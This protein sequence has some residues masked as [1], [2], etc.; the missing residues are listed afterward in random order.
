MGRYPQMRALRNAPGLRSTIRSSGDARRWSTPRRDEAL[1]DALKRL[2]DPQDAAT[3]RDDMTGDDCGGASLCVECGERPQPAR[4]D[5]EPGTHHRCDPCAR[6][7]L[8]RRD[9]RRRLLSGPWTFAGW[10]D[11][12]PCIECGSD[13]P[14]GVLHFR[15]GKL[16]AVEDRRESI[17]RPC[18]AGTEG[19]RAIAE[20]VADTPPVLQSASL[21]RHE[22]SGPAI[23][24][25]RTPPAMRVLAFLALGLVDGM[26]DIG[27]QCGIVT[28]DSALGELMII[29]AA[30]D[31]QAI[32]V[33]GACGSWLALYASRVSV[34]RDHYRAIR[35]CVYAE[36][37]IGAARRLVRQS[38]LGGRPRS[39]ADGS[40]NP[41]TRRDA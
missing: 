5:G 16:P 35:A 12:V 8:R 37:G 20:S 11:P 18:M 28:D 19:L 36:R 38:V 24:V 13:V 4:H 10:P 34:P 41:A 6:R 23:V 39:A 15:L 14:L 27:I 30:D 17:C 31:E 1:M 40:P 7:Y 2:L 9:L 32:Q 3:G 22:R 26:A 21:E 25:V 29:V 33:L